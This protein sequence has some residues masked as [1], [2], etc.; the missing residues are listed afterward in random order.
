MSR[1]R[2]SIA[3][4]SL[5]EKRGKLVRSKPSK[6]QSSKAAGD[7]KISYQG[8]SKDSQ[9]TDTAPTESDSGKH[10]SDEEPVFNEAEWGFE[11][12]GFAQPHVWES[13]STVSLV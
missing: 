6:K 10:A 12:S 7:V 5:E 13:N 11:E 8:R 3:H 9:R 1:Q 4:R 2:L